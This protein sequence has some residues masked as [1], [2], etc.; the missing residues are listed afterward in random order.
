MSFCE[1]SGGSS[2]TGVCSA[3]RRPS[4]SDR[5]PGRRLGCERPAQ[6]V[7]GGL[8]GVL[9]RVDGPGRRAGQGMRS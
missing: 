6:P 8:A 2:L 9:A 1:T 5:G 3:Y 7:K 4:L